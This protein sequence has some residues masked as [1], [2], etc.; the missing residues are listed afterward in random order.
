MGHS[1]LEGRDN[2]NIGIYQFDYKLRIISSQNKSEYLSPNEAELLRLLCI[3][4]NDLLPR[5][6]AL[7]SIWG[8]DT[9]FNGRSRDV[10]ITKLSKYLKKDPTIETVSLH[11]KGVRL[12]VTNK[13]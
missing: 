5:S 4:K 11:A 9:Y 10:F 12:L 3:H 8:E 7:K 6:K 2:F 1:A 13:S